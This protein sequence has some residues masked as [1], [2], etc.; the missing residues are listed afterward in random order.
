MWSQE[1]SPL[2]CLSWCL[3]LSHTSLGA[4][5]LKHPGRQCFLGA[6]SFEVLMECLDLR[7]GMSLHIWEDIIH[8]TYFGMTL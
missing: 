4:K 6:S 8:V 2:V 5:V 7:A 1:Q 3:L